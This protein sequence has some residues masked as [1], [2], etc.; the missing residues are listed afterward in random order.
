MTEQRDLE[1]LKAA[2]PIT[3]CPDCGYS[4]TGLEA[5]HT[6]PECGWTPDDMTIVV[7]T[8]SASKTTEFAWRNMLSLLPL[9][10][11]VLISV[12]EGLLPRGRLP[13]FLIVGWPILI[14]FMLLFLRRRTPEL[15]GTFQVRLSRSG[16]AV[17]VGYGE[18]KLKPWPRRT[19]VRSTRT[20]TGRRQLRLGTRIPFTPML[21][22]HYIMIDAVAA[23]PIYALER[24]LRRWAERD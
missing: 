18:A 12:V 1:T 19:V 17:R 3:H 13:V 22:G 11:L 16:Y 21:T 4:R 9:A 7:Y 15:A 20:L 24:Q 5:A 10:F 2:Y 14:V 8:D 6:C 23:E